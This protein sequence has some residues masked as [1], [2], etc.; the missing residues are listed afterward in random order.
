MTAPIIAVTGATGHLGTLVIDSLLTT[1]APATIV[2]IVRDASKATALAA[3]G[4]QVREATYDDSAA[5]E[6]AFQG[7]DRLL[8]VSGTEM[9]KRVHQHTNVVNAAR[10]AGVRLI[11]YTSAP[12]ADTSTL[13]LAPEH[14][15]TEEV[16]IASG[17]PYAI[18][19]NNWYTE[20]Y[21]QNLQQ[22]KTTGVVLAAS[23]A[24][25]V[26]SASRADY[27]AGA[28]AVLAGEGYE[29]TI[30]EFSGDVAWDF[31]DLAAAI[32]AIIGQQVTYQPVSPAELVTILT[33]QAGLPKGTAEF[34]A[35]LDT[36]IAN[37]DLA[38]ATTTLSTLL[39]RPT[40]PLVDGLR[41]AIGA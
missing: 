34:V 19:R 12:H 25:K 26:A 38:D 3:K 22:A 32:S 41:A 10:A 11:A 37:G 18:L 5:L 31:S 13:I 30:L 1:Q 29:N 2:A 35:A 28:A 40:T 7:V 16:I 17:V 24:G 6:A 15:A 33:E 4:V 14:K 36:N 21:V 27:A 20:N 8:L 23:G 39:G 9:G